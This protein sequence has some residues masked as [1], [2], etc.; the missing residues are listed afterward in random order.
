MPESLFLNPIERK[1]R[2]KVSSHQMPYTKRQLLKLG[3]RFFGLYLTMI[4]PVHTHVY[5]KC[6]ENGGAI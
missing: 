6:T 3:Y 4:R 2:R 5:M 1:V